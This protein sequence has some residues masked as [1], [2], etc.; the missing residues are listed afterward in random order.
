M[1]NA[2]Y[3]AIPPTDGLM[4]FSKVLRAGGRIINQLRLLIAAVAIAFL[5]ALAALGFGESSRD[6]AFVESGQS[7]IGSDQ[8]STSAPLFDG[9]GKWTG[10]AR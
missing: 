1:S 7:D 3:D 10:Y 6:R 4:E 9:H 8:R 2:P 5:V